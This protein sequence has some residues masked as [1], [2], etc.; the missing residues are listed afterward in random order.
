MQGMTGG[1]CQWQWW[2][3]DGFQS[4]G[5]MPEMSC[6]NRSMPLESGLAISRTL[7]CQT[8]NGGYWSEGKATSWMNICFSR[9]KFYGFSYTLGIN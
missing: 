4:D 3:E 6:T 8:V 1:S 5:Q 9:R 2:H 7:L